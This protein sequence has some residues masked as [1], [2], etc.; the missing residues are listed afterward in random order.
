MIAAT[1]LSVV[2]C[3]GPLAGIK[4]PFKKEKER[5]RGE[6]IA[7]ITDPSVAAIQPKAAARPVQLPPP[8]TNAA[9]TE[10]GGTASNNLGHLALP[11][12]VQKVW[13]ADAGTGSS[14]SG[15]LSAVPLVADGKVF[16]LDA[17]GTVSAFSSANGAKLWSASV[18]PENEKSREGFGGGLALDGGRLYV[19]TGYG[20][21]VCIDPV[22]GAIAWTK[23]VG[24]PI[25]SS[26]TA[27]GG[28]IYFVSTDNMLYALSAAD[29][30]QLWTAR[31]LP[32]P[33]TLLSNV[34]PA[35]SSGIVVA[36][37]P[38]GDIA[39]YE[40]TSGKAAWS[41]SLTRSSE[42]T[43]SG[44]LGDPARPVVDHGVVFAVSHGG[45]MIAASETTGERLWSR[46]LA[47]TQMPWVAGDM[48]YTVDLGGKLIALARA[49]GEVR[50]ATDLPNSTRWS[51]PVLAGNKLWLVSGEGVLIGADAR[52]GQI[53]T[54]LD[55]GTPVFISPVVA[56]GRMYIL[57]DNAELIALN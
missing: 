43:A 44:I 55:L 23:P 4:N 20:T 26:P 31:G 30:Q 41:D 51:G 40:A 46:N 5:L 13:S 54:N 37:F 42:T 34:S 49:D 19:T 22:N 18:R 17:G 56:G 38:A 3:S 50:W 52:T 25:R 48:V 47:S 21:V 57:A 8:Q 14:S 29:G 1:A 6:R 35:V 28:K 24:R 15:R 27:A 2:A 10:P 45:K 16:T 39:A 7:V 36:S 9:W 32:Q 53:V 33:A 12:Q 11:D